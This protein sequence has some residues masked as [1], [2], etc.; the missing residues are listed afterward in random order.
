MNLARLD[1]WLQGKPRAQ[2]RQSRLTALAPTA[3]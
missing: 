2:T 1:A 3:A